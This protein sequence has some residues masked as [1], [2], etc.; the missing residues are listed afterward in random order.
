MIMNMRQFVLL[1]API[2]AAF[3]GSRALAQEAQEQYLQLAEIEIV[4]AQLDAYKAAAKEQIEAAIRLEPGVLVLYSVSEKDRP[5]HIKVFEIYRNAEAYRA[6]LQTA[7]FKKYKAATETMVRS[8]KLV[9]TVPV[10]LG[11]KPQ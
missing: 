7:H 9:R 6:H 1:S 5:T 8:L 2:L 3:F 11:A 10:M 4:P